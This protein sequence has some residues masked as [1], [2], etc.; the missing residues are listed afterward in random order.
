[1]ASVD[2]CPVVVAS[3]DRVKREGNGPS[4]ALAED[5]VSAAPS[6]TSSWADVAA[7]ST[8]GSAAAAGA[9]ATAQ[10]P[11]PPASHRPAAL[12]GSQP[13]SEQ[14][15]PSLEPRTH[16]DG[17]S[18]DVGIGGSHAAIPASAASAA[19]PA[20]INGAGSAKAHCNREAPAHAAWELHRVDNSCAGRVAP[21]PSADSDIVSDT[22]RAVE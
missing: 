22:W 18:S 4:R 9:S 3:C 6:C 12:I 19:A 7:T 5:H 14:L 2:G 20:T 21:S 8:S 15:Q 11:A 13:G 17:N 10:L 16:A 1:M